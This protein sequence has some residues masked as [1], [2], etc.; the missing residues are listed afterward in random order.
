MLDSVFWTVLVRFYRQISNFSDIDS[1]TFY[2][3]DDTDYAVI[4]FDKFNSFGN[5]LH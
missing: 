2:Y 4:A 3:F 1:H 5:R